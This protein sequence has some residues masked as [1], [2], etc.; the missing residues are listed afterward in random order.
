MVSMVAEV[1]VRAIRMRFI[2]LLATMATV[3]AGCMGGAQQAGGALQANQATDGYL[4]RYHIAATS[5]LTGDIA[6]RASSALPQSSIR[7]QRTSASRRSSHPS[8]AFLSLPPIEITNP[9]SFPI[10]IPIFSFTL[11]VPCNIP[12]GT[13]FG[14]TIVQINPRPAVVSPI[15]LGNATASGSKISFTSTTSVTLAPH[16]TYEILVATETS[17]SEVSF[18]VVPGSTTNL[19]SNAP[20][21]TSATTFNGLTFTYSS[22]TGAS[23]YSA[24]CF[25]AFANGKLV[26]FLQTVPLVG[27]P[28]FYCQLSTP[29]GAAVTFGQTVKFNVLSPPPDRSF[30]EPDGQPQGFACGVPTNNVSSC[31]VP[32]FSIPTTYQTFIVGNVQDLRLCVPAK[33]DV[34]CNNFGTDP[35]GGAV[36]KVRCC[37]QFQLLVADDPTYKPPTSPA[38]SWDGLFRMSYT[39]GVCVANP[40]PDTD[41]D[42]PPGYTDSQTGIGPAA[43]L[44]LKM[45]APGKCIITV[46]E[47]P[48]YILDDSNPNAPKPRSATIALTITS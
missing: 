11:N 19:T 26:P 30:F 35:Q 44:D 8:P 16:T 47:D 31:N 17:T 29:G 37:S 28:A 27:T 36:T 18:P 39:P 41:H 40:V 23:V 25:P 20:A 34:D 21:I 5:G 14:A 32:Q 10:T 6:L 48:G 24:A 42:G 1:N 12:P 15:K 13:L 45:L 43:E 46:T 4:E 3:L 38:Q 22:S 2:I 9:S 33:L 7:F